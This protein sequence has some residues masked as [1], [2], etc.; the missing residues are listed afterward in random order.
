MESRSNTTCVHKA[1]TARLFLL[2]CFSFI[3]Q[4][5]VGGVLAASHQHDSAAVPNTTQTVT[6]T[7]LIGVVVSNNVL[8]KTNS[9]RWGNAGAASATSFLGD[10]GLEFEVAQL[11]SALMCGLSMT[12]SSP[13][14]NTI[15]YAIEVR[16]GGGLAVFE[17]GSRRGF[18]GTSQIGDRLSVEREGTTIH[19][20][21][22]GVIFY[23]S[24]RLTSESLLA[25]CAIYHT[26]G[27]ILNAKWL[28]AQPP[29]VSE[30]PS[31]PINPR[32]ENAAFGV[33][34]DTVLHWSGGSSDAPVMINEVDI[35]DNDAVELYNP[36][37]EPVELGGWILRA[38]VDGFTDYV[39]PNFV[40]E[41][42][43][44][45]VIHEDSGQNDSNNI[46]LGR[47]L[48]WTEGQAGSVALLDATGVGIDFMRWGSFDGSEPASDLPPQ[49]VVWSGTDI[50]AYSDAVKHSLG[51]DGSGTDT[52]DAADWENTSGVDASAKTLGGPNISSGGVVVVN[53]VDIDDNDAV[54][55]YNP[56][57]APVDIS[58]WVLRAGVDGFT[59][60]VLPNF[61][62]ESGAFVVIHEESGTE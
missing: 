62:L 10:G 37:V 14:F 25:D 34:I 41:S 32:P 23:T 24:T 54:E 60:Y 59:D 17:N 6:W 18:F 56:T 50:F 33:G 30:P 15:E 52:D 5:P 51:R 28:D 46:Y 53:E 45:V 22:N 40:L 12:D 38:G 29:P 47:N 11:D 26:G 13:S 42:G 16:L 57:V 21:K 20:K 58:G 36:T 48:F 61:V 7:N 55:L 27:K 2:V 4:L 8:I 49:G 31:P 9:W 1:I 44:F 19:Y 43:A 3:L 39:L 35:D